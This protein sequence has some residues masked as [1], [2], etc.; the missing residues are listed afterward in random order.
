M[1]ENRGGDILEKQRPPGPGPVHPGG[2]A[3]PAAVP[4][5]CAWVGGRVSVGCPLLG[6]GHGRPA[7]GHGG[8]W[9]AGGGG[10]GWPVSFGRDPFMEW[11]QLRRFSLKMKGIMERHDAK[12]CQAWCIQLRPKVT[13]YALSK[14]DPG[15]KLCRVLAYQREGLWLAPGSPEGLPGHCHPREGASAAPGPSCEAS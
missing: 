11:A 14:V 15:L 5:C 1:R 12:C 7:P 3:R 8:G 10:A 13:E 4:A 2:R 9:Q 6:G